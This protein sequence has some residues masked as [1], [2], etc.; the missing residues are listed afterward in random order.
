LPTSLTRWS[1]LL[2]AGSALATPG[3]AGWPRHANLPVQDENLVLAGTDPRTLFNPTWTDVAEAEDND[4]PALAQRASLQLSVGTVWTGRLD[5][6]GW[7]DD[8]V[9]EPIEGEDC[10]ST[11][12]RSPMPGDY[13]GDV[14]FYAFTV[15][16]AGQLCARA[17]AG[18]ETFGWDMALFPI[19]E[20]GVPGPAIAAGDAPL[21]V[22]L[23]GSTGWGTV[24][25]PGDY[26]V[27]FAAYF[28][29]DLEATLDYQL[30]VAL[31]NPTEAEGAPLC[32][33]LPSETAAEVE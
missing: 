19:D 2:L 20:C 23:G 12:V 27:L 25:E 17:L 8:A 30:G 1:I 4:V 32:P 14:D 18:D 21:G 9:P 13:I 26:A 11:G 15:A 33:L 28:P 3:C 5:G 29:N 22:D 24:V 6:T 31:V 10:G 7:W 16:E